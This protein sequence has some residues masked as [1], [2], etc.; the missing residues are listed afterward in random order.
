MCGATD[1]KAVFGVFISS[2]TRRTR[3]LCFLRLRFR[4]DPGPVFWRTEQRNGD[5]SEGTLRRSVCDRSHKP[6]TK[7]LTLLIHP[8]LL[9]PLLIVLTRTRNRNSRVFDHTVG[10]AKLAAKYR[11]VSQ[12]GTDIK[13][14]T[15]DKVPPDVNSCHTV[16]PESFL[17]RTISFLQKQSGWE[18]TGLAELT[19]SFHLLLSLPA[20]IFFWGGGGC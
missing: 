14:G 1:I 17:D 11:H 12:R 13:A 4:A 7:W 16:P 19:S 5:Q 9:S 20:L 6:G 3:I 15:N 18:L 2:R 8:P 10:R